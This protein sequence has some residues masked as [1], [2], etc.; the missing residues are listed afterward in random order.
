MSAIGIIWDFPP[1][2]AP[3][4]MPKT[5]PSEGSLSARQT[6]SPIDF[7]AS[8]M[9]IETVVLPI[10][11]LVGLMAVTNTSLFEDGVAFFFTLAL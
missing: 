1:P 7:S 4:F 11:A 10:P 8:A 6:L 2:V 5:G 9:P 3:P